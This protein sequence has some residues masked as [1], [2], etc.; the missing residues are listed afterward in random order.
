LLTGGGDL[1]TA[2]GELVKLGAQ[3]GHS[4]SLSP[5]DLSATMVRNVAGGR[6]T[7]L[8]QLESE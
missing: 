3:D 2:L 6:A 5:Y 1:K 4:T 8:S 7:Q